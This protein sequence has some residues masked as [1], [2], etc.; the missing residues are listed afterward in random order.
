MSV[1]ICS[2]ASADNKGTATEPH[3]AGEHQVSQPESDTK[4]NPVKLREGWHIGFGVGGAYVP[5]ADASAGILRLD[6][7][8]GVNRQ[9]FRFS[10]IAYYATQP[11]Q[12]M[13]GIGLAFQHGFNLGSTY[14]VSI[15]SMI[16]AHHAE[17]HDGRNYTT[18]ALGVTVSPMTL[19]LGANHNIELAVQLMVL[20]E[21]A[22]DTLNPGGFVSLSYL[23]L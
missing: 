9:D 6:F 17:L 16:A 13:T 21:Y 5:G 10:P 23:A 22:Y 19:R 14:T 7:N 18:L 11:D 4:S 15:G 20:R 12:T 8:L 1:F 3:E 2:I